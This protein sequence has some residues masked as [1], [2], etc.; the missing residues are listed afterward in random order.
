MARKMLSLHISKQNLIQSIK[1][2]PWYRQNIIHNLK[3]VVLDLALCN[4]GSNKKAQRCVIL[5]N[6]A[7][8]AKTGIFP[9][10]TNFT[11][12]GTFWIM[13]KGHEKSDRDTTD[14]G[15]IPYSNY[16]FFSIHIDW[17]SEKQKNRITV[18]PS[19]PRFSYVSRFQTK[20]LVSNLLTFWQSKFALMWLCLL[21]WL[22]SVCR[23]RQRN[24]QSTNQQPEGSVNEL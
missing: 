23:R 8:C 5:Y 4:N 21:H 16:I 13:W 9:R 24:F 15:L 11:L 7:Y 19:F 6:S 12:L 10:V 1:A 18:L 17:I 2:K 20:K 22:C 3:P 14:Y